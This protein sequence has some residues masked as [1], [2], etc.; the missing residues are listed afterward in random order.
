MNVE[1]YRSHLLFSIFISISYINQKDGDINKGLHLIDLAGCE[2]NKIKVKR[3]RIK[4]SCKINKNLSTL[5]FLIKY[6]IYSNIFIF[7]ENLLS[8]WFT[9]L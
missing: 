9:L 4:E 5:V 3:E 7:I 6:K 2:K 1:T 8:F